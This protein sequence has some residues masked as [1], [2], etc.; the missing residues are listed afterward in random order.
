MP[1]LIITQFV[2][3]VDILS[4]TFSDSCEIPGI[5]VPESPFFPSYFPISTFS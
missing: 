5:R 3:I 1:E 2:Q 4:V